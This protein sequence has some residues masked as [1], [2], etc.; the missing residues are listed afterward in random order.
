MRF[1][2]NG[3][4]RYGGREKNPADKE[5]GS[6]HRPRFGGQTYLH[7]PSFQGPPHHLDK[8]L[9]FVSRSKCHLDF[10]QPDGRRMPLNLLNVTP[11]HRRAKFLL[12]QRRKKLKP[13]GNKKTEATRL[14]QTA[15]RFRFVKGSRLP[16]SPAML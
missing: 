5:L 3:G 8:Y 11:K 15:S 9:S 4:P 13:T 12:T 10:G 6:F 14:V 7:T 2:F 1:P 16:L